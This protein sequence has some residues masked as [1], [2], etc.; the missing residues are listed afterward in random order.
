METIK[1]WIQLMERIRNLMIEK[2][3]QL[4]RTR[5]KNTFFTTDVMRYTALI[6]IA[7]STRA[8][9]ESLDYMIGGYVMAGFVLADACYYGTHFKQYMG[10]MFIMALFTEPLYDFMATGRWIDVQIQNPLFLTVMVLVPIR[11]LCGLQKKE[12]NVLYPYRHAFYYMVFA[13]ACLL[14]AK[15]HIPYPEVTAPAMVMPFIFRRYRTF[16]L[17]FMMLLACMSDCPV[18]VLFIAVLFLYNDKPQ[19]GRK[20]LEKWLPYILYVAVLVLAC[21]ERGIGGGICHITNM[22]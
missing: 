8:V 19:S 22:Q 14:G 6:L 4:F 12:D 17:L 20:K 3:K 21:V 7:F 10:K 5:N 11:Y 9:D 15:L 2:L 16:A 18:A 13:A 1:A